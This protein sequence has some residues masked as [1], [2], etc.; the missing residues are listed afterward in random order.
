MDYYVYI[1]Y[2]ER[3]GLYYKGYTSYPILRLE[4]HNQG[5]SRYTSG[6]GPW[7]MVYLEKVSD[8][9]S[10][11]IREKQ[12]KRANHNYLQWLIASDLNIVSEF[13]ASE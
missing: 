10:A 12:I 7:R 1:L 4:E 3:L 11:L 13:I 5:Q 6:K 2:S 9:K 8:K